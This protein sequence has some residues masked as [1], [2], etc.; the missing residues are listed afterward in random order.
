MLDG[1]HEVVHR[2]NAPDSKPANE[3]SLA[4]PCGRTQQG[5]FYR[6]R[7][8][9]KK[10]QEQKQ[11]RLPRQW[12]PRKHRPDHHN[13]GCFTDTVELFIE[14]QYSVRQLGAGLLGGPWRPD[15]EAP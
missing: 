6:H 5:K 8:D 1:V 10:Q 7:S 4:P 12:F 11:E 9:N 13:H 14:M 3:T 15:D 2:A